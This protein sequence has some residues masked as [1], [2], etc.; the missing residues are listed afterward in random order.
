MDKLRMQTA[1]KADE[2]FRKLAAMFP[3]AVTETINENGEVVRAID[4][5]VLM[6]EI[7]CSVVDGNEERY[8]FTWP[9]KKKSVLLA[10]APIN[11]TLRPC[12][13][14]S[15]DFDTTENL[16]IEGDNLEVLKLL[17]ETYLGKIKMIYID[18]PY[19]T[20]SDS[21][22]YDDDFSMSMEEFAKAS[23]VEDEDG[24]IVHNIQTNNE[25]NCRFHTDWLNMMYP[26]LKI[27]KTMLKD[28]GVLFISIDNNEISNMKKLCDEVFGESSFVTII[29]AQMSTVQGQKV[30][31]AKAGNIVKNGEHI[32]VYSRNGSKNI[33]KRPLLDPVKYDN[34]YSKMLKRQS[35][36]VFT[37]INLTDAISQRSDIMQ[38]LYA[39][40]LIGKNNASA[41]SS[42]NIQSYYE[43]SPLFKQFVKENAENIV[44][45]HDSVDV[46]KSFF[47]K[48]QDGVVYLYTTDSR[49]Y[50]VSKDGETGVSQRIA[51][52]DKLSIADDFY[53]TFGPTT[54]RGDWWAGFYLDM[55][56]VSKEGNVNY[57]NGKKP[58]RLIKQLIDFCTENGDIILDFFSGSATT[59]HAA[60]VVS[61]DSNSKR[62]FIMVQ[63][64]ENLDASLK[65][66]TAESKKSIVATIKFLDSIGQPH[67]L[68]EI[69]KE[70][71]R[72][73][74]KQIKEDS[75]LTTQDLDIGFRVLKCDT[76]NMKEVYY[77]PAEYE[78]SLFSSLEDNIKEDRT[79]EDLLFQVMLD[80]GVLLSGKIEE[81]TIAGKKVFNVE[82]NYLI[83]CFDSDVTEETITA[84]A[85]QKP[86]YFVMRD[87]SMA[88][89]SVATNFDQI[90]ATYS[91]DTVRKVL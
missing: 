34:H 35:D 9:D 66:A 22:V 20:G 72:R 23:G 36:G 25:A 85:K 18:P 13:E 7:A 71:L 89:D 75:P 50:L 28:D 69:G 3:N 54:I 24:N 10:N 63:L 84:I 59:A 53:G 91:P 64:D 83:A 42:T 8:Q 77:N 27:C 21:F 70:R 5:D 67:I 76:S 48:M 73:A 44:R 45:V 39:L 14:E 43:Y 56:N 51:L 37:E 81:T 74:G 57:D 49:S 60:M 2:N 62:N 68:S 55:G 61:S 30:R 17:Q 11:K 38:E 52:S 31:A 90:F 78:A 80:L 15:V 82:D 16:Y 79:P 4:K 12:R 1:N 88:N 86:Y 6:Q 58:V 19:N 26:R 32:L 29:H 46:P 33:G 47:E 65:D 87:S 41:L 40:N